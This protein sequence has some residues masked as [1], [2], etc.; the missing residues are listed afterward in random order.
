MYNV[1]ADV[2]CCA[3]VLRLSYVVVMFMFMCQCLCFMCVWSAVV[4][5]GVGRDG[6][7]KAIVPDCVNPGLDDMNWTEITDQQSLYC[8]WK[9]QFY[10]MPSY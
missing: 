5:V 7:G 9:G 8:M 2:L 6:L 4:W 3:K 1:Y 10:Q